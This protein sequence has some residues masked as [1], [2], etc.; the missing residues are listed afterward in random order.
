[1][2]AANRALTFGEIFRLHRWRP[3]PGCPGRFVLTGGPTLLTAEELAGSTESARIHRPES[4]RDPVAVLFVEG[5]GLI[6]YRKADGRWLH[7]LCDPEGFIRKL[8]RLGIPH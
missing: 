3:I 1:M 4:A 2:S 5:G 8:E 7:T 6:S